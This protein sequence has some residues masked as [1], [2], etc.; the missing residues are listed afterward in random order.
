MTEALY[1]ILGSMKS[2]LFLGRQ[3]ALG[4]A[5]LESLYGADNIALLTENIVAS[6]LDAE[7]INFG[8]LGGIIK[9]VKVLHTLDTTDW[10]EIEKYLLKTTPQHEQYVPEGKLTVG[11]S[12]YGLKVH[13]KD[14]QATALRIKK[15]LRT[16]GR[17][18]RIVPNQEPALSSAQ[19]LHNHLAGPNGW[20]L[21]LVSHGDKTILAQT[22]AEQNINAYGKRDQN[23]PKRDARVGMLPPKLAQIL[24]NL[25]TT[26]KTKTILDP[27]CGTGVILQEA[28]L[29]GY[30]LYGSDVEPRMIEFSRANLEWLDKTH[31]LDELDV[32]LQT[33]DATEHKWDEPFDTVACEGYL[34]QPFTAFPSAEKL[35][36]VRHITDQIA[37]KFLKNI[38]D[39]IESGSRIAIALPAWHKPNGDFIHLKLLDELDDLGYNRMSFVHA[40]TRD[41]LY[42]RPDQVVARELL[43]ITRK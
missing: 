27:F 38:A 5:E 6:E 34:G 26:D 9:L 1:D 31:Q 20:E 28:A 36:S 24:I 29:M 16:T 39:Q 3:P 23:R 4:L 30:H 7:Q 33:G 10:K 17:S 22:V 41:L 25:S 43:V 2:L 8:R 40:R 18:V 35:N 42:Y 19:V 32:T 21:V 15:T 12:I 37:R 11:L 13:L 14:I